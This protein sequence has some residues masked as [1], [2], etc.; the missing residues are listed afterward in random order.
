MYYMGVDKMSFGPVVATSQP[1][2]KGFYS[3]ADHFS[4]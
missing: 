1:G 3:E 2:L 4:S